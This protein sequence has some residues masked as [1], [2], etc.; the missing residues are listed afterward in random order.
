MKKLLSYTENGQEYLA[1]IEDDQL[2]RFGKAP[3]LLKNKP[4]LGTIILGRIEKVLI[5]LHSA[6]VNIGQEEPAFLPLDGRNLSDYPVGLELPVQIQKESD[7]YKK[8]AVTE[9][10]TF[11]GQYV[12]LTSSNRR[13]GISKKLTDPQKRSQLTELAAQFPLY[14]KAGYILRTECEEADLQNIIDEAQYLSD[15]YAALI[16]KT[17]FSSVGDVLYRKDSFLIDFIL[18]EGIAS[19]DEIIFDE[20]SHMKEAVEEL[21][22]R[23]LV[24]NEDKIRLFQDARWSLPDIYHIQHQLAEAMASQVF[25]QDQGY[26]FIETTQALVSIDVNSG[27]LSGGKE[28]ERAVTNANM[29]AIPEIVRQIRLRNLSGIILIDF[30]NM[31]KEENREQVLE[32]LRK[33]FQKDKRKVTVY[34]FTHL[35]LCEITREKMGHPLEF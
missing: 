25:L 29:R 33:E 10:L 26:L 12:V 30:I 22:L 19:F 21:K 31:T 2:V 34:G 35:Q 6:Y 24:F 13:I 14:G 17:P 27:N 4:L 3:A 1:L 32:L 28:K 7:Q 8:A 18:E 11:Q 16:Q 5:P 9:N 20:K 23:H 15:L